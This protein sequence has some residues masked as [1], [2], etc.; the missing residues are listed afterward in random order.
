MSTTSAS[1][2]SLSLADGGE[3]RRPWEVGHMVRGRA[4]CLAS[5]FSS[6]QSQSP[7][8]LRPRRRWPQTLRLLLLAAPA[9]TCPAVCINV[10]HA[11][12]TSGAHGGLYTSSDVGHRSDLAA[13]TGVDTCTDPATTHHVRWITTCTAAPHSFWVSKKVCLALDWPRTCHEDSSGCAR[14]QAVCASDRAIVVAALHN[15][16]PSAQPRPRHYSPPLMQ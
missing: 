13:L 6:S 12:S 7:P 15:L 10:P 8:S 16:A 3:G 1:L 9:T 11:F 4:Q 14:P 5:C 2:R